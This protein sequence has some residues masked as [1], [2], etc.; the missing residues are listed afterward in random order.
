MNRLIILFLFPIASF[1]LHAQSFEQFIHN[2]NSLPEESRQAIADS[3][4]RTHTKLPIIENDTTVHFIYNENAR[5]VDMAGDA[6]NWQPSLKLKKVEGTHL[7]YLTCHYESDA[8]LD[9]KFVIDNQHWINDPGNPARCAGGFGENSELRMP[10]CPVP[11]E[12]LSYPDIPSGELIDSL[13]YSETL[14][15]ARTITIY[16][17]AEYPFTRRNYPIILFH[18]GNDYL[19]FAK[20]QKIMD[21]LIHHQIIEPVIGIFVPAVERTPEFIGPRKELYSA[22][23]VKELIPGIDSVFRTQREPGSRAMAGV[24]NGGNITLYTA[25]RFPGTIGN[26]AIQSSNIMPE[27]FTTVRRSHSHNLKIYIDI[28]KYDLPDLLPKAYQMREIL[29]KKGYLADFR[30]WNEGHSWGN[31]EEHLRYPLTLFFPIKK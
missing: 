23:L 2:L 3:F 25:F 6:T 11:A 21:Y 27:L 28:G 5:S 26:L 24:S 14:Q 7:W 18:D 20:A 8:R 17:P 12:T 10:R 31:W 29:A 9:Y 22:F 4:L 30:L 1:T 13:W 15:N 16:L 19:A